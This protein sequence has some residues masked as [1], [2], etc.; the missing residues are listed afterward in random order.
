MHNHAVPLRDHVVHLAPQVGKRREEGYESGARLISVEVGAIRAMLNEVRA[1][2]VIKHTQ[3]VLVES[4]EPLFPFG[5]S[6]GSLTGSTT[7][8]SYYN[9]NETIVNCTI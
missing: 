9:A 2:Q 5:T 4:S 7:S 3:V 1:V 6:N 8:F